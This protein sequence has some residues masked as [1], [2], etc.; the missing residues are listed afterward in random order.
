MKF[1]FL[2]VLVLLLAL[3]TTAQTGPKNSL[4]GATATVSDLDLTH[5]RATIEVLNQSDKDITA[6]SVAIEE[7]LQDNRVIHSEQMTDYG[8]FL[9]ARGEVLHPGETSTQQVQFSSQSSNPVVSV[10]ATV[11]AL[12]FADQTAQ[13]SNSD[14]L[15]RISDHRLSMALMARTSVE[16]VTSALA[17]TSEHPGALAGSIIRDRINKQPS[18]VSSAGIDKEFMKH[19]AQELEDTPKKATA[20]GITERQYLTQRLVTLQQRAREEEDY[21]QI[22]RR[23]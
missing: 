3:S 12:V 5:D 14:A 18:P 1:R 20:E 2:P 13:A 17:A 7:V 16:A 19:V 9:T 22:A 23:P 8:S 15:N 4:N 11:V 21:S 6:F 10:R